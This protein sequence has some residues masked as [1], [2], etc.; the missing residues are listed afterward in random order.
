MGH[1][2]GYAGGGR[3]RGGVPAGACPARSRAGICATVPSGHT[4]AGCRRIEG[5]LSSPA[6]SVSSPRAASA[7]ADARDCPPRGERTGTGGV[8]RRGAGHFQFETLCV[9]NHTAVVS[10]KNAVGPPGSGR[11]ASALGLD[12]IPMRIRAKRGEG[13]HAHTGRLCLLLF[14]RICF[15]K[16]LKMHTIVITLIYSIL[17]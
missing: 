17:I 15:P 14:S 9:P 10:R 2:V 5:R 4:R 1:A 7:P 16:L 3:P 13:A 6:S 8:R 12:T 11:A